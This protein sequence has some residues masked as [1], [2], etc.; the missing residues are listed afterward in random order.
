[1]S[2]RLKVVGNDKEL[3]KTAVRSGVPTRVV[4]H[5]CAEIDRLT[6]YTWGDR[7]Y[8]IEVE[9]NGSFSEQGCNE[10]LKISAVEV[11]LV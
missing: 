8:G 10:T 6:F 4:A 7:T 1:M 5:I 9:S 3:L 11:A 2:W